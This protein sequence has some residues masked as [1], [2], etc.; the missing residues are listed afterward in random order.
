M[1]G[2]QFEKCNS[3]IF[4][5]TDQAVLDDCISKAFA[6]CNACEDP[7]DFKVKLLQLLTAMKMKSAQGQQACGQFLA[8]AFR[9]F[10]VNVEPEGTQK[11]PLDMRRDAELQLTSAKDI[12][13]SSRTAK[14]SR[15]KQ[16]RNHFHCIFCE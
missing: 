6:V 14:Q 7:K 9:A 2:R 12:K 15:Q 1:V 11:M 10:T 3:S 8:E 13:P 4:T 16:E 5:E